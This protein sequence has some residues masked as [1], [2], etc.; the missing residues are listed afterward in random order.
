MRTE[1]QTKNLKNRAAL[2]LNN[3]AGISKSKTVKKSRVF[4]YLLAH[5]L[6][7]CLITPALAAHG[8]TVIAQTLPN[9]KIVNA[10]YHPGK[11]DAPAVLILHGFLQT[12]EFSTV[13]RMRE[14]LVSAGF[15]VLTPTLSLGISRRKA[16]LACE[17]LHTH[18][19]EDDLAEIDLW[20][21]WLAKRGHK[22]IILA[23]HSFGSLQLVAYLARKQ[24]KVDKFIAVSLL[25][26]DEHLAPA[27]RKKMVAA[28]KQQAARGEP[29]VTR[30][31]SYCKKFTAP[32]DV[33]LSYLTWSRSDVLEAMRKSR[34]PITV[35]MGSKDIRMGTEW[36]SQIKAQGTPIR[37]IDGANH[38]FDAQFE[39]DLQDAIVEAAR[40]DAS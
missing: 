2:P 18:R 32:P 9:R 29:L 22:Q 37:L 7:A 21:H 33:I 17:A 34:V 15:T 13:T 35:I 20:T 25:D 27:E 38:F 12:G 23:G 40:A 5:G 36:P 11:P 10:D 28:L 8:P 6:M 30:Q 3:P 4:A 39:F 16:P 26:A 31:L 19:M 1:N 24:P 14:A